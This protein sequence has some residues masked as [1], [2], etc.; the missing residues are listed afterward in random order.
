MTLHCRYSTY[1]LLVRIVCWRRFFI[2]TYISAFFTHSYL[3][4]SAHS[5]RLY[6]NIFR[7]SR[8]CSDPPFQTLGTK[9]FQGWS[10]QFFLRHLHSTFYIQSSWRRSKP[11]WL[12]HPLTF[13]F[14]TLGTYI[15]AFFK[16]GTA[17][18]YHSCARLWPDI[19]VI[20]LQH[21]WRK[22]NELS[23]WILST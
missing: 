9:I 18:M 10:I 5:L 11:S 15:S 22:N 2:F 12:F 13:I 16:V 6:A 23:Y 14:Q 7:L 20:S 4:T 17:R 3:S 1:V 21:A 19:L 8:V